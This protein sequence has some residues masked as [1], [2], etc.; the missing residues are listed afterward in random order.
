VALKVTGTKT[1]ASVA[2][3]AFKYFDLNDSGTI[4]CSEFQKA[5]EK[6]G[7]IN[8]TTEVGIFLFLAI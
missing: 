2:I 8:N 3:R 4:G 1:E 7:A 6:L 5:V